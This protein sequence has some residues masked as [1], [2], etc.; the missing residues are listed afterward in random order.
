MLIQY[1]LTEEAK[2]LEL[3][4]GTKFTPKRA[5]QG[6]AGFDLK[7][8]TEFPIHIPAYTY[9][10]IPTGVHMWL[11]DLDDTAFDQVHSIAGLL[12]PRS[13]LKGLQ[14]TNSIG[15]IDSDYQGEYFVSVFNYTDSLI[16]LLPGESIAQLC[17]VQ[18]YTPDLVKV[19]EF[20]HLTERG[21]GGFGHTGI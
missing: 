8:C 15:L 21:E 13:S 19:E 14:L 7:L 16:R 1:K 2:R 3:V 20:T 6:S 18:A 9:A 5:T 12:M 10:K 11:V 4:L 17:M